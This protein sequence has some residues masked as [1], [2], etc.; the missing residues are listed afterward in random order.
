[1]RRV[2]KNMNKQ[3]N[4][5][6]YKDFERGLVKLLTDNGLDFKTANIKI[7]AQVL[8]DL[9]NEGDTNAYRLMHLYADALEEGNYNKYNA[10]YLFQ[11]DKMSINR[12][13]G[14]QQRIN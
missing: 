2:Y 10:K 12:L 11:T 9:Y 7:S 13:R 8:K 1:M 4:G 5:V 14:F 3:L 6:K